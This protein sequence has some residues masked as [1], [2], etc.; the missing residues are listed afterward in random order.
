M[1]VIARLEEIRQPRQP[2]RV[3]LGDELRAV[4]LDIVHARYAAEARLLACR[5]ETCGVIATGDDK[6]RSGAC[7]YAPFPPAHHSELHRPDPSP[8]GIGHGTRCIPS[9]GSN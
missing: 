8:T 4:Q 3:G 9:R 1:H 7:R 6:G 2:T 5:M